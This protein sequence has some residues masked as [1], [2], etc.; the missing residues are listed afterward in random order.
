MVV[1]SG[2]RKHIET[3]RLRL[4]AASREHARA[5]TEYFRREWDH[6]APWSPPAA[7]DMFDLRGQRE[8]MILAERAFDTGAAWRWLLFEKGKPETMIGQIHFNQIVRGAFQCATLGY[9]L[10][11]GAEGKGMMYEALR[12]ALEEVFSPRGRLHRVQANARPENVR[13]LAL[14]ER[15]GFA[16]EGLAKN[17]LFI[18]RS[19]RDHVLTSL[20]NPDYRDEWR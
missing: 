13:S 2:P 17:Y 15:L 12:A 11:K 1:P 5:A 20:T 6:L 3:E 4:V 7:M 18:D 8:R 10:G 16:R 9:G 19:W 14:L